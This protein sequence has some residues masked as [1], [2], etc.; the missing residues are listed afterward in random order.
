MATTGHRSISTL[1]ARLLVGTTLAMVI[2]LL[3]A[4]LVIYGS[5]RASLS[6]EF[7]VALRSSVEAL[8]SLVEEHPDG[9]TVEGE[10]DRIADFTKSKKPDYFA[11]YTDDGRT[12]K[13]STSLGEATLSHPTPRVGSRLTSDVVLPDGLRGRQVTLGV[14][15]PRE[16]SQGKFS[17]GSRHVTITLA[18]HTAELDEKL[19]HLAWLLSGVGAAATLCSAGAML[20]VVRRGLRP[21][22]SLAARIALM[23]AD[24]TL[25]DR[26]ELADT[27][28]EL[29]TVVQ[30]LN[31][32]LDRVETTLARERRFN[33]DIAH[34]LRTPLAGLE[35]TLE[36]C[37]TRRRMPEE[38]EQ[39]LAKCHRIVKGMHSLVDR[40]M[41]LARA[42]VRQL[43]VTRSA[44]DVATLVRECWGPFQAAATDKGV[45]ASFAFADD[46]LAETDPE[47]F[48]MV[49]NNL[50]DNAVSHCDAG[51][52]LRVEGRA[53]ADGGRVE[54][55]VSNSG[56]VLTAAQS[57]Q[58]FD[59]FWRGDAA[60]RNTGVHCGLGLS[61]CR[62]LVAAMEGTI[63]ASSDAG[64]FS[65][66]VTLP[67]VM[68]TNGV[69]GPVNA[70]VL[71][72]VGGSG[73]PASAKS[74]AR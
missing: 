35:M 31:E 17:P 27:P 60:R 44:V 15:P 43:P 22:E 13:R 63:E 28:E 50:L 58:V 59:R 19:F 34:E 38:Y 40:L 4:G 6:F 73:V 24:D 10:T 54:L 1:R 45:R 62:E 18:R 41:I 30:R 70:D 21:L 48:A 57:R 46:L 5:V 26:V 32:L 56:S 25:G 29:T 51:G 3:G 39:T 61:L 66:R 14:I 42:D 2:V 37:G 8:S 64:V 65:V 74:S 12:V 20:L 7:D 16:D 9:V 71:P 23:R 55:R 53:R 68:T 69:A 52:W 33:A 11:V 72:D 47:Q 36:V 49:V 67:A